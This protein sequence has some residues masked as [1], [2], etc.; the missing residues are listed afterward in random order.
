MEVQRTLEFLLEQQ[1]NTDAELAVINSRIMGVMMILEKGMRL[2][3]KQADYLER[4][5]DA[6]FKLTEVDATLD[7]RIVEVAQVIS[8]IR[9]ESSENS[10]K[11]NVLLDVVNGLI[12]P[13]PRKARTRKPLQPTNSDGST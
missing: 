4:L 2:Q 3:E 9:K 6:Q 11:F 12:A 13:A 10:D 1:A 5:I 7:D 8:D